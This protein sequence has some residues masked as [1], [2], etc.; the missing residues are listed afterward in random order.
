MIDILQAGRREP[1]FD[2]DAKGFRAC[3]QYDVSPAEA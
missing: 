1:F 2:R 3:R